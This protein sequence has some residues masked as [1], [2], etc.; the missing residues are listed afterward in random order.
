M[1]NSK[2]HQ[3]ENDLV[4]VA[5]AARKEGMTYGKYVAKLYAEEQ[6][7]K[8]LEKKGEPS[9]KRE[10]ESSEPLPGEE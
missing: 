2:K 10:C 3:K 1:G 9:G 5:V 7:R 6:R 8:R 4:D